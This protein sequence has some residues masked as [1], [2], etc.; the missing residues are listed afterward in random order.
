MR[1]LLIFL[2]LATLVLI[3]FF[4]WGDDLM[5]IFT[6]EGSV[7][8]LRQ[9]GGWAWGVAVLLLMADLF[10]PL[11][12]TLIMSALGYIYGPLIGGLISTAGSFAA[13]SLGYWL[14]RLIGESAAMRL[15][16]EKDYERGKKLSGSLGGWIVVVSRWL[17]VFPEV[18]SCMA[19]LTR[20]SPG[21]FHAALACGSLPLGFVYAY[22]GYE[23]NT[24]P[25]LAISLSVMLPPIIWY[26][27]KK[28]LRKKFLNKELIN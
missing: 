7:T 4:I 12:A 24:Y 13:G 22:I 14:C 6:Q 20:M 2:I 5:D 27:V 10:L 17:P 3:T 23:G 9:Y 11:P 25:W 1:L 15:L 8:W 18:I 21:Y 19:G 28:V 16:G 26:V